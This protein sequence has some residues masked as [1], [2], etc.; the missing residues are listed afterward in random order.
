MEQTS[1]LPPPPLAPT[2]PS[3]PL[4]GHALSALLAGRT[5]DHPAFFATSGS[6]RLAAVVRELRRLGWPV[7]SE[8]EAATAAH[9]HRQDFARYSFS[10]ETLPELRQAPGADL[11]KPAESLCHPA[12]DG[13]V[14]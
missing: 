4:A 12:T 9:G 5:L 13:G 3:A 1:F 14:E 6:W 2:W 11:F 8:S 10:A 7:L